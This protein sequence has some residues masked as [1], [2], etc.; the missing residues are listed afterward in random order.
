LFAVADD[1]KLLGTPNVIAEMAKGF[2]TLAWEEAGPTTQTVKNRIYVHRPAQ[3]NWCRFLDLTPRNT[4]SELPVHDI[5]DGSERVDPFDPG[6]ER[7][8]PD[9]N[10]VNIL[11]TPL[12]TP[13]F[14]SSYLQ[15]KGRKHLLILKFIRDV[16]SAEFLRE[17]ELMLKGTAFPRLS[18]ILRSVQKNQHSSRRWMR[19][20]DGA[21][22]STWL[23]CL[24]ASEDL[25][26]ALGTEG[27]SQLSDLL[28][29]PPSY[30][31]AG[32]LVTRF[33]HKPCRNRA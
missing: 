19:D 25:E 20:M 14:V 7:M 10:G 9:E 11:G 24:T 17:A 16:A 13:T 30:G 28:D 29:L 18:D 27:R 32:P 3:A 12:R 4:Q 21:H 1:V 6:S 8:W 15:R 33:L 2:P 31:G 23:H 26:L 5:P 22:L